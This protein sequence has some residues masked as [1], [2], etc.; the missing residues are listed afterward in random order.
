MDDWNN[1]GSWGEVMKRISAMIILS[2]GFWAT[3][4]LRSLAMPGI[5]NETITTNENQ[6]LN[7]EGYGN[8]DA[9]YY[10]S[11]D[12]V[13]NDEESSLPQENAAL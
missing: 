1:S 8:E 6:V 5:D 2:V 9:E 10:N 13:V 4:S 3:G 11:E 7:D 12:D